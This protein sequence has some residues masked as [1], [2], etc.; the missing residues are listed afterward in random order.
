MLKL[1]IDRRCCIT[2]TE[3]K[4]LSHALAAGGLVV[5]GLLS[6]EKALAQPAQSVT[7]TTLAVPATPLPVA[8][9]AASEERVKAASIVR[10]LNY[11]EWPAAV[12]P[13]PDAPYVIGVVQNQPIAD[14]LV[15][16]T[17]GRKIGPRPIVIRPLQGTDASGDLHVVFMGN[18]DRAGQA[19]L[20]KQFQRQPVLIV[21]E[22]DGALQQG[23]MINF[24]LVEERVR[25]EVALE[26]VEK[27]GL[28]LNSRI[29]GVAITVIKGPSS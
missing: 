3:R 13:T 2:S 10:F 5:F 15:R 24:R 6:L 18:M 12:F 1:S 19:Q 27:S 8:G 17:S 7:V 14:E 9:V 11:V 22:S 29:L 16:L 20:V 23:S 28:K 21:T 26:P 4:A 25:F